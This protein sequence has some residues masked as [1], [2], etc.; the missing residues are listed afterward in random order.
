MKGE[1]LRDLK[2]D[3]QTNIQSQ[4]RLQYFQSLYK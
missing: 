3:G 2:E 1:M 4:N